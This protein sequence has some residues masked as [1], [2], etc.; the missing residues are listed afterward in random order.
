MIQL[1]FSLLITIIHAIMDASKIGRGEYI[2]HTKRA[3][4]WGAVC[5]I[6]IPIIIFFFEYKWT[7][8][9]EAIVYMLCTRAAFYDIILNVRRGLDYTYTSK[10]TGSKID[11]FYQKYKINQH[12]VRQIFLFVF[13]CLFVRCIFKELY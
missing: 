4:I 9:F 7:Y 10:L 2:D 8:F 11:L 3:L 13:L 12:T 1:T 5:S 6:P